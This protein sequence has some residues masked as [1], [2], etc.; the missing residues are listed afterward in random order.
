MTFF[1]TAKEAA[2]RLLKT[3][4]SDLS[5][6]AKGVFDLVQQHGGIEGLK[7]KFNQEG[8]S[9]LV[10]SW[11]GTGGNL[12]ISGD[13]I[14]KVFGSDTVK[15]IAEKTGIPPDQIGHK[16]AEYLPKIIDHL[17]P[18]GKVPEEGVTADSVVQAATQTLKGKTH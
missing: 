7:S 15:K 11:I 9:E 13:Q 8:L 2:A 12:P 10:H 16:L 18:N 1:D 4:N 14:Q 6:I 5:S 3:P 17:T